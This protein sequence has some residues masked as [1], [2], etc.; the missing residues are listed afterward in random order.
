MS[1]SNHLVASALA[2]GVLALGGS[3]FAS[4]HGHDHAHH[5]H[6]GHAATAADE[7]PASTRAFREVND[8]MHAEMNIAFTGDADVDFVKGMIPHHVG[9]I[10]MARVVLE[11]GEDEEIRALA[12]EIISAQEQEIEQMRAWLVERGHGE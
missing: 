2:A 8:R 7:E 6:H 10:E 9:A 12:E 4:N 11:F 5:D 1:A 3:A